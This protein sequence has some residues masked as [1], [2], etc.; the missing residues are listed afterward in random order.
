[1]GFDSSTLL[2][3]EENGPAWSQG[4]QVPASVTGYLGAGFPR[5]AAFLPLFCMFTVG[6]RSC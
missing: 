1:M 6:C 4:L 2:S 3:L 5:Q